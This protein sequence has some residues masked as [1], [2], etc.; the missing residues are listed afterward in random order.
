MRTIALAAGTVVAAA[1]TLVAWTDRRAPAA[2]GTSALDGAS[3]YRATGCAACHGALDG[4]DASSHIAPSLGGAATW[5]AERRPGGDAEAY[6]RQSVQD[7]GVFVSPAWPAADSPLTG[8]PTLALSDAEL[9]A[10]VDD[11]LT[12]TAD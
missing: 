12:D 2:I 9:T 4:P 10:L 7:P 6:V 1:L 11:L 3:V 8:M 5:A